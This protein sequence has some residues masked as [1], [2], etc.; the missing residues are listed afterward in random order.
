MGQKRDFFLL[1]IALLLVSSLLL[2][3]CNF[4][5]T[6]DTVTYGAPRTFQIDAV[7]GHHDGPNHPSHFE[8]LNLNGQIE[9]IEFPGGD[10]SHTQTY[11]GPDLSGP[12]AAQTAVTLSFVD[13][14]G[15]GLPDMVIQAQEKQSL[16]LNT[17]EKFAP[18]SA[19]QEKQM[20]QRLRQLEGK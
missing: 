6:S 17:G 3:S 20:M 12:H 13:L 9:V 11:L 19:S 5:F 1:R 16:F 2:I 10:G 15:D 8:A 4:G 7:V 18:A 14:S